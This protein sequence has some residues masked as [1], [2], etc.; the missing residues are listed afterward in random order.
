MSW[1]E[2]ER[3]AAIIRATP[4]TPRRDFDPVEVDRAFVDLWIARFRRARVNANMP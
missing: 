3:A 4:V 2:I 1:N